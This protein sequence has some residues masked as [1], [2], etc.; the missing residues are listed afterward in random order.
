MKL[1]PESEPA[2]N[3]ESAPSRVALAVMFAAVAIARLFLISGTVSSA[4]IAGP[5][6]AIFAWTA[7]SRLRRRAAIVA[8]LLVVL[9]ILQSL[10]PFHF[11]A[12]PRQF[13]WIPFVGFISGPRE[14]GVRVFSRRRSPTARW[15]GCP[16]EPACPSR[17]R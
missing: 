16:C 4:E 3:L 2:G 11:L 6:I 15:Y 17:S 14:N 5:C 13:G 1:A 9:V 7:M 12:E 10:D 8:M